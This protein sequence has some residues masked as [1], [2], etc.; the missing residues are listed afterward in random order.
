MIKMKKLLF[1]LPVVFAGCTM[2][3]KI[4]YKTDD[5]SA[6]QSIETIPAMVEIRILADNRANIEENSI[7]FTNPR[8]IRLDGKQICIN[9]EKHY[10]NEP[11]VN[12]ITNLIVDHFN[13]ARL[14]Q[15]SFYDQSPYSNY[16]LTGTLN[17]FYGEQEFST[18]KAVGAQFGL[19]GALATAGVKTPG[20]IVIDISDLRLYNKD[21]TLV[22]D[23]GS[24][25]KEYSDD[26]RADASCWCAY[27]SINEMLKDFNTH[28]VGKIRNDM[29]EVTLE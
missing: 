23:F 4:A 10:K 27:W 15:M 1:L 11:V 6:H 14:F 7:L 8:Q 9:S 5:L 25:Y 3:Q 26:F 22:K 19:I 13:R 24:L 29:A 12:Q 28:L 17:S 18:A 21:E 20:K 2:N 16:Y